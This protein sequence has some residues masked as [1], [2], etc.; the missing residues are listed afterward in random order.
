MISEKQLS[1]E[2]DKIRDSMIEIR[3]DFHM[4]PELGTEEMRT[5]YVIRSFLDSLGI[6]NKVIAGTGVMGTIYGENRGGATVGIRADMD[7]LPIQDAKNVCYSS[8]EHGK[9]HAC[10]HDAHMAILLGTAY[11]LNKIKNELPGNV[12]LIFQPAEETAGGARSM[13]REGVLKNPDV[14]AVIGLHM[15][16]T[17]ETGCIGI[18]YGKMYASSSPFELIILGHGAHG[19]Y[20]QRGTDAVVISSQVVS[21]LQTIISRETD[22]LESA[23]I[24]IGA[25]NGGYAPNVICD[26]VVLK[27]IIRTV[28][29]ELKYKIQERMKIIIYGIVTS[30]GGD[31]EFKIYEGYPCLVN[32]DEMVELLKKSACKHMDKDSIIIL[33]KPGMGVDDF[34]YFGFSVPSVF[35]RLGCRNEGKGIVHPAH[36]PMFDIDEESIP[37]GILLQCQLALDFLSSCIG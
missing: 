5:S 22:P 18:K 16:E 29:D 3:R 34:V 26:R 23:V 28:S 33:E 11:V 35:Y 6:E 24:T 15:D 36:S 32:D 1:E 10:G 31:W 12:R 21:A 30:M 37:L 17:M 25:I 8:K 13:I 4:H 2:V 19:A 20:P 14:N 9:M 7:A 27:G